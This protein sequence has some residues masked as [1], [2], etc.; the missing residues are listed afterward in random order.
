MTDKV[1][2]HVLAPQL[3]IIQAM[4]ETIHAEVLKLRKERKFLKDGHVTC[5]PAMPSESVRMFM[6]KGKKRKAKK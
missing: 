3:A 1:I 6:K 5:D 2:E 4:L